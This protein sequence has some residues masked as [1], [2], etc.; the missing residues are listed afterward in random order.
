MVARFWAVTNFLQEHGL[1]HRRLAD[2]PHE[3]TDTFEIRT[4]DLT[5]RGILLLRSAY[6]KYLQN[7]DRGAD[8]GDLRLFSKQLQKIPDG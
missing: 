3:I 8:P 6:D 1:T 4:E 7:V 2:G 5:P